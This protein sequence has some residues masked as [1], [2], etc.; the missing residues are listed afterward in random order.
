MTGEAKDPSGETGPLDGITVL[1]ASRVLAGPFCGMQLADLG[2][3]VIKVERPDTGDQTRGWAPPTYRDSD[4]ASYYLSVN[5]NKR[6]VTLNLSTETGQDLFGELAAEADVLINNFRVGTMES[7]GLG[8]ETLCELNPGLIYCSITGYGEWGPDKDRPAYDLVVQ[9]EGGM[10]SITGEPDGQPVRVGVAI[11]DIVTGLYSTQ[12]IIAALLEREIGDGR[13]QKLDMS[14]LDSAAALNSYA[15]MF[16]FA[17]GDPPERRGGKIKNIV[18][19][20]AFETAD[21]YAVIAVPSE[22]LWP[23]FCEALDRPDLLADER[24]ET[25]TDRVA[26]RDVL[27]ADLEAEISEYTTDEIV[28]LMQ[29]HDVP[30]TPIN[31]MDDVYDHPQ[32]LARGMRTSVDH[33]DIGE[34]EM[35]GVPMHFS[36]TPACVRSHPPELGEHTREVL[37]ELDYDEE[38]IDRFEADGIV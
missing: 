37:H 14:L 2:A 20:Q 7:W 16:Y 11:T 21:D 25:N 23:K 19:Y 1:D 18:P 32:V 5:R 22:H 17:T 12:S 29:E 24:F 30:A 26:N 33:P 36:R 4:V 28:S 9:A 6:S 27:E 3:D 35:P 38:T 15:A 34:V 13:G 10:M 8:Y 31:R